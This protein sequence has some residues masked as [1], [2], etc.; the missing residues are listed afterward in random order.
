MYNQP[1]VR[2]NEPIYQLDPVLL[3]SIETMRNRIHGL[4]VEYMNHPVPL[5]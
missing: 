3:D 2:Q 1:V 4:C 5:T